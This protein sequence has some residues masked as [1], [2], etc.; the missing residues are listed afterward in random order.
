VAIREWQNH[1]GYI[2]D[3]KA[4]FDVIACENCQFKHIV[5]VPSPRDLELAYRQEYYSKEKPL[6][7]ERAVED[8]E[9]W[10]LVYKERYDA[11][12]EMLSPER[13][14]ILDVGSG[15]GFFLQ[16]GKQRGW[17]TVGIEP[18][19]QATEHSR[20]LGLDVR[21]DFL[22]RESAEDLGRFDVVHMSEVLEHIPDPAEMMR[23]AYDLLSP[24]GLVCVVV[25]ND[26]SPFQQALV[27]ACG[28]NSWWVAP[29]H[30]IN[31]FNLQSLQGL[32]VR[33]HFQVIDR[34][35]TFPIDLFLLM[36]DNYV[37]NDDLGR[38]CHRKRK[39]FELNLARAG[40][41]G[42]RRSLYKK[43]AE[44]GIGREI[45]MIGRKEDAP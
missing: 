9:W 24:G 16:H 23:L 20:S 37:G 34:R 2:V 26:F 12:E 13:R 25:P 36:G 21:E 4:G 44:V 6:Y 5:P 38:L 17:K 42:L 8:L 39:T 3:T 14:S 1:R 31:Y 43:I 32:F 7:I 27:K 19:S 40:Q 35:A 10:N 11:F 18:S 29:P 45:M 22:S 33:S 28:Y 41:D 15:P 30:H